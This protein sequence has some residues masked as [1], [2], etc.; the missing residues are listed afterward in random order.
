[1]ASSENS[2]LKR[3]LIGI[4]SSTF[5][6]ATATYRIRGAGAMCLRLFSRERGDGNCDF[7]KRQNSGSRVIQLYRIGRKAILA[8]LGSSYQFQLKLRLLSGI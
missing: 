7:S 2:R 4:G 5:D 3:W 8:I 1:M 6:D